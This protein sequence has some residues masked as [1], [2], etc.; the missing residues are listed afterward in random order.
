MSQAQLHNLFATDPLLFEK[1]CEI[2]KEKE[3]ELIHGVTTVMG[4]D[5]AI[6]LLE[7]TF[8]VKDNSILLKKDG[9]KRTLG[10]VFLLLLRRNITPEQ[11]KQIFNPHA[12]EKKKRHRERRRLEKQLKRLSTKDEEDED[13]SKNVHSLENRLLTASNETPVFKLAAGVLVVKEPINKQIQCANTNNL[14]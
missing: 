12:Q 3:K 2:L 13:K 10:G 4:G 5:F 1:I 7:E 9:E 6:N 11:K 14:N 8:N